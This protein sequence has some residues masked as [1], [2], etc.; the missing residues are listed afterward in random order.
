[1]GAAAIADALVA[2]GAPRWS[3]DD[4]EPAST[5]HGE[6]RQGLDVDDRTIAQ[7]AELERD[8]VSF[9]KG[10][11]LGQELV[12]RIDARGHVNRFLRRLRA[13][14]PIARGAAVLAGGKEVGTVTS[15]AGTVGLA[16]VR[17]QVEPGTAVS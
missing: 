6:A 3:D 1:A 16:M 8:A 12:C 4:Y 2:A 13:D 17:R 11:F 7:E 14:T 15:A 5:G 10:C 9:T